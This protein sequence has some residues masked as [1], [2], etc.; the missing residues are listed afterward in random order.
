MDVPLNSFAFG[1]PKNPQGNLDSIIYSCLDFEKKDYGTIETIIGISPG[2]EYNI[3]PY[4][5]VK[6]DSL[7]YKK[8]KDFILT[9]E[10]IT[11]NFSKNE[12]I[13]QTEETLNYYDL[14]LSGVAE[15]EVGEK[16][17]QGDINSPSSTFILGEIISSNVIRIRDLTGTFQIGSQIKSYISSETN[18]L[19]SYVIRQILVSGK[20]IIKNIDGDKIYVKRITY[21]NPFKVGSVIKGSISGASARITNIIEDQTVL[22]IGLN[23]IVDANASSAYGYVNGIEI[24]DSGYGYGDN[25]VIYFSSS[26]GSRGGTIRTILGGYG[27]S[28]GI[29]KDKKG[30]ISDNKYLHDGNYYQEYS[31]EVIS[32]IPFDRYSEM[33]KKVIHVSGTKLFGSVLI[34]NV[35]ENNI[36]FSS[37]VE[38]NEDIPPDGY[39]YLLG[40]DGRKLLGADGKYLLA[41]ANPPGFKMLTG[42]D[43]YFL[44]GSDE[45]YI[46]GVE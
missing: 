31:Y 19:N 16:L 30:F 7:Y 40:I 39:I 6:E 9:V 13:L 11:S 24:I 10:D 34:D 28:E 18:I 3:S 20:G 41:E 32:K 26:D 29:Y 12:K 15:F 35:I 43:G 44:I 22:Q 25:Q 45:N 23:A 17:Y 21:N 5:L 37:S 38:S 2:F 27:E 4:V 1:F 42:S 46:M 36:N 8:K 14:T 33:F